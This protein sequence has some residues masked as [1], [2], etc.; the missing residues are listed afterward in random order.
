MKRFSGFRS[1]CRIAVVE[2]SSR[3]RLLLEPY[4]SPQQQTSFPFASSFS[5]DPGEIA[6]PMGSMSGHNGGSMTLQ[7]GTR[8]GPYELTAHIGAGG[9]GEVWRAVDPRI[10]RDV[11][12]KILPP[13]FAAD[14]DRLRRFELEARAAGGLNHPNILTLHDLGREAGTPFIVTELL[15]GETLRQ[16]IDSAS[17]QKLPPRK[18]VEVAIQIAEGLAAAH[19][20]GI[21]HR[22]LKPE[23]LFLTHEGRV[24]ILD[25]GLA[26]LIVAASTSE[27]ETAQLET[28]HRDTTPGTVLG[29]VGYMSPEQVRGQ[30]A[31][32]RSD[33]FSLGTILYELLT[34]RRPFHGSSAADTMSAILREEPAELTEL[35]PD[36]PPALE[37]IVL[38][39]LEK[40]P[41][42]RYQSSRDLAFNLSS[43]SQ[44]SGARATIAAVPNRRTSLRW[45]AIPIVAAVVAIGGWLTGRAG[46]GSGATP[47][48]LHFRQLTFRPGVEAMPSIAPDGRS[49]VFATLDGAEADLYLQRLDGQNA[50]NLTR[51]ADSRNIQP[52]FSPDGSRIA[53]QSS[54]DGGGIFIMGATGESIRRVTTHGFHPAWSPDGKQI[55]FAT[56]LV[57]F[58]PESRGMNSALE[59]V[60]VDGGQVRTFGDFDAVH[61]V[62]SPNGYRIAYWGLNRTSPQ[63][64]IFTISPHAAE[65]EKTIVAVT[66]DAALDWNP[67][68]S[69]D[70]RFLYFGSDRDGTRNLWRVAIDEKSGKVSGAPEI[71]RLPTDF[72]GHFSIARDGTLLYSSFTQRVSIHRLPID[73]ERGAVTGPAETVLTGGMLLHSF[74]PS[75]DN[76]WIA[77]ARKGTQEDIYLVSADGSEIRQLTFDHHRDRGPSFSPDGTRI[78]FYSDRE[79]S[80]YHVWSVRLDGSDLQ[81][82]T[83]SELFERSSWFPVLSADGRQ[84]AVHGGEGTLIAPLVDG[85]AT[86]PRVIENPAPG[87]IFQSLGW[88]GDGKVVVGYLRHPSG[89]PGDVAI[90]HLDTGK[91]E[92]I[93]PGRLAGSLSG[94][95][96]IGVVHEDQLVLIDVVS[97]GRRA[98]PLP[99]LTY[100]HFT[101]SIR[102][103]GDGRFL[104]YAERAQEANI[105]SATPGVR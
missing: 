16:M 26:K 55:A 32:H 19:E 12:I 47:P 60:S 96:T 24:K 54:R 97:G 76:Q 100:D 37:R 13:A 30:V 66:N 104:Y 43:L 45:I 40:K 50:I 95:N 2:Q 83:S 4:R 18:V 36:V 51:D 21:V 22:D 25:F 28:A 11:A 27:D 46:P 3:L 61:P 90:A 74:E 41:E 29:T 93:G 1:R 80:T 85:A 34:G 57:M 59:I 68:W 82:L 98:I 72:A 105:W 49:F 73:L 71:V 10:G 101:T 5:D 88:T 48:P 42:Q 99:K 56:A 15:E 70:G 33:I 39:C 64:D 77:F 6:G 102:L 69:P 8:L 75:P 67:I 91:V 86:A 62:W 35:T 52:A 9:M 53:F 87:Q 81:R 79:D 31:D 94:G 78:L 44:S 65:P 103:S 20:R 17:R 84:L 92:S 14:A 58:N 63:R 7:T 38:H 89:E 23:N